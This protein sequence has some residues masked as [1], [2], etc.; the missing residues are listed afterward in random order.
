MWNSVYAR[1]NSRAAAVAE[2]RTGAHWLV[3]LSVGHWWAELEFRIH[4]SLSD[5]FGLSIPRAVVYFF[6]EAFAEYFREGY[7]RILNDLLAGKLLHVDETT[8]NLQKDKGYV[9]VLASTES[10]Y[11]FYRRSR[12]G[13]FLADMLHGFKGVLVSDFFTAYDSLDLPQQRC[14]VHLM[15]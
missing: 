8:I 14:L 12:E 6:K 9:W 3:R 1:R 13:S 7:E 2:V 5:L 10:V 11:F 4:R 15:R